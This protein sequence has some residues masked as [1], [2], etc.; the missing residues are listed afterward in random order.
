MFTVVRDPLGGEGG[1]ERKRELVSSSPGTQ[2]GR[3]VDSSRMEAVARPNEI[4]HRN[5]RNSKGLVGQV[6]RGAQQSD[7]RAVEFL[8][9]WS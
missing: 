1:K 7:V 9:L 6:V 8:R 4:N 3:C 5:Q 2:L